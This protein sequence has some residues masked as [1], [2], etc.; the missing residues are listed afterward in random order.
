MLFKRCSRCHIDLPTDQ[1]SND[2]IAWCTICNLAKRD[3]TYDEFKAWAKQLAKVFG[4]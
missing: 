2:K 4:E 3:L 1:F